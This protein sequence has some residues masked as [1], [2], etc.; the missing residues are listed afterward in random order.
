[1]PIIEQESTKI[2]LNK[3]FNRLNRIYRQR[4][5]DWLDTG[6]EE[7]GKQSDALYAHMSII[8][9]E[10]RLRR[11]AEHREKPLKWWSKKKID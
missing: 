6:D 8:A 10:L 5:L 2:E 9:E 3:E 4:M 11:K 1:M 7:I